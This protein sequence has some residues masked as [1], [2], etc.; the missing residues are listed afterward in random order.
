MKITENGFYTAS[1]KE[2]FSESN[3][4]EKCTIHD[5]RQCSTGWLDHDETPRYSAKPK[6]H[7]QKCMLTFWW[8]N[9]SQ[10]L[11]TGRDCYYQQIDKMHKKLRQQQPALANR[12]GAILLWTSTDPSPTEYHLFKHLKSFLQKKY[13]KN[14]AKNVVDTFIGSRTMNFYTTGISKPVSFLLAEMCC[15]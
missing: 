13:F 5:N 7:Q 10:L 15:I 8:F 9:P 12:K 6:L 1:Q 14:D 2:R 4:D 11:R 3:C